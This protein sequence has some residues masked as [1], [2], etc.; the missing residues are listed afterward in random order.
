MNVPYVVHPA[1]TEEDECSDDTDAAAADAISHYIVSKVWNESLQ[2]CIFS[3][4]KGKNYILVRKSLDY[5]KLFCSDSDSCATS[6]I[7]IYFIKCYGFEWFGLLS[8]G[9]FYVVSWPIIF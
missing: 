2:L 1:W 4:N 6:E 8:K 7:A 3:T 5:S 9:G